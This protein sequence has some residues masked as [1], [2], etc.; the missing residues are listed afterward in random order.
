MLNR[1]Q[2]RYVKH[3]LNYPGNI[4]CCFNITQYGVTLSRCYEVE[5]L[6]T[7]LG[8]F[9]TAPFTRSARTAVGHEMRFHLRRASGSASPLPSGTTAVVDFG[10]G[11]PLLT[12]TDF[13]IDEEFFHNYS[14]RGEFQL[15]ISLTK[16]HL[17]AEVRSHVTA[18][19]DIKLEAI[20]PSRGLILINQRIQFNFKIIA[21]GIVNVHFSGSSLISPPRVTV[22]GKSAIGQ[23]ICSFK[24]WERLPW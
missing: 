6:P 9:T 24:L 18:I 19:Q 1:N 20:S 8:A 11:S 22:Q 4:K 13:N 10:D 12:R 2:R 17:K 3:T 7:T 21:D 23:T 16:L 15:H 14:R 5:V